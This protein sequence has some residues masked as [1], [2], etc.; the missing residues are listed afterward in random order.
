VNFDNSFSIEQDGK[1]IAG[2]SHSIQ[3]FETKKVG[4]GQPIIGYIEFAEKIDPAKPFMVKHG[5]EWVE[6]K[7]SAKQL[8]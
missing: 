8:Q 2:T 3:N 5:K 4:K 7:F 6:F 1:M